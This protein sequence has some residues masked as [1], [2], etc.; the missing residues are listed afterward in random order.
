[1]QGL[2]L[3]DSIEHWRGFD[4]AEVAA[5]VALLANEREPRSAALQAQMPA[6]ERKALRNA[7]CALQAAN[8]I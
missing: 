4:P 7:D 2:G 3:E 6:L 8:K 1:M 5:R